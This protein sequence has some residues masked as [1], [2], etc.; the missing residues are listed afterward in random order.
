LLRLALCLLPLLFLPGIAGADSVSMSL[1]PG[2]EL[3]SADGDASGEQLLDLSVEPLEP[4]QR[5]LRVRRVSPAPRAKAPEAP[6]TVVTVGLDFKTR[7][8][9]GDEAKEDAA[10][11]VDEVSGIV[12]RSTFGLTGTYR[13]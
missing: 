13:F 6:F 1:L 3:A 4:A 8:E 9:V 10:N 12:E 5:P 2:P 7:R 11:L